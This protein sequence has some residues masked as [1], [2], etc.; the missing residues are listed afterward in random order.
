MDS[1]Q[2]RVFRELHNS[3]DGALVAGRDITKMV[4]PTLVLDCRPESHSEVIRSRLC[5][6]LVLLTDR[7]CLA[8]RLKP[9]MPL[10]RRWKLTG[11][12]YSP[13]HKRFIEVD[14]RQHFSA[15]RVQM[16][17]DRKGTDSAPLYHPFFWRRVIPRFRGYPAIDLDPP[18]RDEQR[19]YRDFARDYLPRAYALLPTIRLDEFTLAEYAG[20]KT[21]TDLIEETLSTGSPERR[22]R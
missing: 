10:I 21:V 13:A 7:A 4:S 15:P 16:L 1:W 22:N 17:D 3:Y 2:L 20:T 8:G 14:E 19:A 5:S 9:G 11:D 18:F 6:V 12:M